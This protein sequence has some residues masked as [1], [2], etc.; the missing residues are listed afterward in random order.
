MPFQSEKQRRY[1]HANHPEIAKRWE[2]EYAH[3]GILDINESE[4]I[5]TDD[6]NDIELTAYNAAFDDPNDLSTGVK[7]LFKAKNGGSYTMQG[8]VKNYLGDQ[9]TVS[10][11]PIKWRSGP[12][13]PPTELAYITKAEKDLLLK[14]DLHGSL[15]DGPNTGPEGLMSLDSQGDRGTYGQT[16]Q[17]YGDRQT[18]DTSPEVGDAPSK[19]D[20]EEYNRNREIREYNQKAADDAKEAS[21]DLSFEDKWGKYDTN[22]YRQRK[23]AILSKYVDPKKRSDLLTENYNEERARI[24]KQIR[25]NLITKGLFALAG[26]S[27]IGIKD[28]VG[29][30][31]KGMKL[32]GVVAD[33]M[34]LEELKQDHIQS[35]TNIKGDLISK[36]DVNNPNEMKSK[37]G[38][39][40]SDI[41]NQINDLTKTRDEDDT[42]DGGPKVPQVVPVH[43]EIDAYEDVYAMSPWDRLKANQAQRAMLVEKGII[44]ENPV[45]DESVTDI[46]MQ[47]NKGGLANLF[48][49]KN[50]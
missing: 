46:T 12:D 43:E 23:N 19:A 50:Q 13:S 28:F 47:A 11:V 20:I 10:H 41:T 37:A 9:E 2:K 42:R 25:N 38:T 35:L 15:K 40:I 29:F 7:S 34:T 32:T 3:G 8:G 16:G 49:V 5:T 14:K 22:T 33:V 24:E 39:Q 4:E 36:V 45:V 30:D 6:G 27:T 31:L 18:T 17:G 44:Q 26:L 21:K 1:L 48:R